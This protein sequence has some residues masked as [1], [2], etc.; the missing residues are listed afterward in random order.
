MSGS[1][2]MPK[3]MWRDSS[4]RMRAH[5]WRRSGS[6]AASCI[7]LKM[8]TAQAPARPCSAIGLMYQR[9][10]LGGAARVGG[11]RAEEPARVGGHRVVQAAE[12]GLDVA[13]QHLV[14]AR[15]VHDLGGLA[16]LLGGA[17]HA[18]HYLRRGHHRP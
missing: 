8:S 1:A 2:S 6:A 11:G 13:L 14:V 12:A 4:C 5:T 16:E 17:L 15:L 7:I 9:A 3:P 18:V 10:P